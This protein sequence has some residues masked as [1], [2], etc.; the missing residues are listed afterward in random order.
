MG[1]LFGTDGIRGVANEV[2][3]PE[4]VYG[5]ARCAGYYFT[6]HQKNP[7]I[8]IGRDTRISGDM[9]EAALS[10]GFTS[11]GVEVIK[12]GVVTTPAVA[13]LTKNTE[14]V[15]GVMISASHNPM[16]DN[17]IKFFSNKGFKLLDSVENEIEELYFSKKELPYP[18]GE[19][20]GTVKEDLN[21]IYQYL[22]YIKKTV[23]NRFEGIKVAIDCANGSAYDIGPKLF[24]QLGADV[25][26]LYNTPDG[27]NI[28]KG[29]GSTYPEKLSEYVLKHDLD[30]GFAFDGDADRLIAVDKTGE[31]IDGDY[32]LAICGKYLKEKGKLPKNVVVS[33]VMANL[34]FDMA[35]KREGLEP[36]KTKVGDRYVLEE[37]VKGG[38]T[39]GGEQSGHIIFLEHGT[40]GDGLLT[41]IQLLDTLVSMGKG[42]EEA[43]TIL[44]KLPQVLINVKV[45]DKEKYVT[46]SSITKKVNEVES[47]LGATGRVL[48]RPSGTENLIRVMLEGQDPQEIKALAEEIASVIKS[49]L[50]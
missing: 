37:M 49:E 30:L 44:E 46:N 10:L 2:L 38:Y 27:T 7:K 47:I 42:L 19:K 24:T 41:A 16:E 43:K 12:I 31:I 34:G 40:T 32:I 3:T 9:I 17:G 5:I 29:C 26:T 39:L 22:G 35:C 28:N 1:K 14:A 4:L 33:T 25:H 11:V 50:A 18:I 13:Y 48:V 36:I 15:A 23:S 8:L 20:V 21:L 45:K 6:K